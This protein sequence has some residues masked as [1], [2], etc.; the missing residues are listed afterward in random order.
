MRNS[1]VPP[2]LNL[3][4][5][6]LMWDDMFPNLDEALLLKPIDVDDLHF[7]LLSTTECRSP[8]INV[9][10]VGDA[11]FPLTTAVIFNT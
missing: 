2:S 10:D 6:L 7:D 11:F 9:N 3:D 1:L 8:P 5:N 4:N